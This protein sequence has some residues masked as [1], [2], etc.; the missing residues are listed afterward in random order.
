MGTFD[1]KSLMTK[2]ITDAENEDKKWDSKNR[3]IKNRE[4]R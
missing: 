1:K 2:S 4:K 3:T